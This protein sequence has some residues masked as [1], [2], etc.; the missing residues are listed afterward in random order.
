MS[1]NLPKHLYADVLNNPPFSEVTLWLKSGV[2][3]QGQ[4]HVPGM[5]SHPT[6]PFPL[7]GEYGLVMIEP[8]EIAAYAR[9]PS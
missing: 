5:P 7:H 1:E 6:G 4:M 9:R 3:L 2:I 8:S